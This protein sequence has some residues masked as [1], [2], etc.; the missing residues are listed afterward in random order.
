[1][2]RAAAALSPVVRTIRPQR[3]LAKPQAIAIAASDPDEEQRVDVQ[4]LGELRHA[5]P[6]AER[7]RGQVRRLRAG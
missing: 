2:A 7:D 5:R 1:M 6:V 4:R 3:V